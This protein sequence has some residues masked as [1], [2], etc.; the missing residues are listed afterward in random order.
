MITEEVHRVRWLKQVVPTLLIVAALAVALVTLLTNHEA[1]YGTVP[2]PAGGSVD[3]PKGTVK[4]FY[5]DASTQSQS[6]RLAAPL[7]FE[8]VPAGGGDPVPIEATAKSGTSEAQVQRSEDITSLGSIAK[9]DVPAKGAYVVRVRSAGVVGSSLNFGTDPLTAVARR[10][11]VF[12][13][14]FGLALLIAFVPGPGRWS[15][16]REEEAAGW[17]SDPRAPYASSR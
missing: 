16:G 9:L 8:V 6:P 14:L 12:A 4:V 2:M 11:E 3:L 7:S 17:S 15:R 5:A 10:W 1:D 13:V